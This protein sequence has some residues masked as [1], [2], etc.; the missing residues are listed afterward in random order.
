MSCASCPPFLTGS[1]RVH[2]KRIILMAT[3]CLQCEEWPLWEQSFPGVGSH[4]FKLSVT[5]S[6][7]Y[8]GTGEWGRINLRWSLAVSWQPDGDWDGNQNGQPVSWTNPRQFKETCACYSPSRLYWR[9]G[10]VIPGTH[11][12]APTCHYFE[13]A[14]HLT[15]S[16]LPSLL[17]KR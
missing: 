10:K 7:A 14:V 11:I 9:A 8:Q 15:F 5:L 2:M 17:V 1:I 4:I 3:W 6:V 13:K 16:I 12:C